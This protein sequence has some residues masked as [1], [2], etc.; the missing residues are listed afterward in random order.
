MRNGKNIQ[1]ILAIGFLAATTFL[2]QSPTVAATK[3]APPTQAPC[4][5]PQ[6][7]TTQISGYVEGHTGNKNTTINGKEI[8]YNLVTFQRKTFSFK[9]QVT[10]SGEDLGSYVG[11]VQ[12][13]VTNQNASTDT[14]TFGNQYATQ[15]LFTSEA[16]DAPIWSGF[17]SLPGRQGTV[18]FATA[19]DVTPQPVAPVNGDQAYLVVDNP[20]FFVGES[21][22]SVY[23]ASNGG[24]KSYIVNCL[25]DIPT[26]MSDIQTGNGSTAFKP[27][28]KALVSPW[29]NA[30]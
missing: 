25:V 18:H 17:N 16:A 21:G 30:A 19:S 9:A 2:L 11:Y 1:S 14:T 13:F 3:L 12:G 22:R 7:V 6:S 27:G 15:F 29:R 26:L 4:Y 20:P 8:V 24:N 28:Q 23:F 5:K 10:T